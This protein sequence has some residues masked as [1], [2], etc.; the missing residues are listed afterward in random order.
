MF[1]VEPGPELVTNRLHRSTAQS[2]AL[3]FW[4]VSR[5]TSWARAPS[6]L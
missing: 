6:H 1:H 2:P 3:A 4:D 5:A